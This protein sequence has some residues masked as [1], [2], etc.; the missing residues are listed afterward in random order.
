MTDRA[1]DAITYRSYILRQQLIRH[2][3][4]AFHFYYTS[5]RKAMVDPYMHSVAIYNGLYRHVIKLTTDFGFHG[6][7]MLV[8]L[9][10]SDYA[11]EIKV[12]QQA[13]QLIVNYITKREYE[14]ANHH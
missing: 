7:R 8:D 1:L 2:R 13:H 14:H 12:D 5:L 3:A 10:D 11:I 6:A 9:D 4:S